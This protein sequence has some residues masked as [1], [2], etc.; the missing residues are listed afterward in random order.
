[1][2][3][4][5]AARSRMEA[6]ELVSSRPAHIPALDGVRAVAIL[7]VVAF[8]LA[9]LAVPGGFIG[10][11]VF[12]VLS[13]YLITAGLLREHA[14]GGVSFRAFWERRIRRLLPALALVVLA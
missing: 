5:P 8:H 12:F 4:C 9:P 14:S 7:M 3:S 11:D 2:E 13:G 1:C 6:G 10:V